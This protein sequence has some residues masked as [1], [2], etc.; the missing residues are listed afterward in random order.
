MYG[1][2]KSRVRWRGLDLITPKVRKAWV[3]ADT[4][5]LVHDGSVH[6]TLY[7]YYR[8]TGLKRAKSG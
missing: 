8:F 3:A 2:L 4:L 7:V 1:R 5:P 6:L